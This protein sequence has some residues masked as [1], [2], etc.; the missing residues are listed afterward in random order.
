MKKTH[1]FALLLALCLVLTACGE[2]PAVDTPPAGDTQ[3]TQNTQGDTQSSQN[4]QDKGGDSGSVTSDSSMF[5]D[6]DLR[7]TYDDGKAAVITLSGTSASCPSN[8]VS[9]SGGAVTIL[10]EGTYILT[11]TLTD[12][13]IVVNAPKDAKTQLVLRD[14]SVHSDSSAALYVKAADK[15]VVTLEGENTLSCG[16]SFA[17]VDENNIDGA[18]YAKADITF[19]GSGSLTVTS[20]AG[21]GIV[22]KDDV[23]FA[24][25]SYDITCASHGVDA[26][27][28]VRIT[29]SHL[30]VASGKDAIHAENADDASLGFV[31]IEKGTFLLQAEGDG[32]SAG[33]TLD[34]LGGSFDILC[35]GGSE[36]GSKQSSDNWG[37]FGGGMMPGGMMPGGMMPG[38]M[39]GTRPGGMGSSQQTSTQGESTSMKGFKSTGDLSVSGG[40]FAVDSAD[41]AF[42]S[43]ANLTVSGGNFT[44][45]TG[46]D[47]FHADENL[48]IADGTISISE[49]YEGLEG[50]DILISGGKIDLVSADDGINAAGGTDQSGGG[51]RDQF[52]G[53]GGGFG[54]G[55]GNGSITISGGEIYMQA[56]GDGI[57]ANGTLTISGG[58]TVV[59][60]P[61]QG[62]TAVLDYD[63]T[64]IITGGTFIGTGSTMMAQTFSEGSTQGVFAVTCGTQ[65]AGSRILLT[66]A[67][68][69]TVVDHTPDLSFGLVVLSTPD[70]VSGQDYTITI[71]E[72][73]GTFAAS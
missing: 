12:G 62:D 3:S 43:N 49:S 20:P 39:G 55:S 41:D 9:V 35:G 18:V 70:M 40:I 72:A 60:G 64:A 38:G 56:S 5:T 23:V 14:V 4:T 51:G 32:I 54:M 66:D 24:G 7:S 58:Y 36:N 29:G 52:G 61:T 8:A 16:E 19:N 31:F 37:G 42:H 27:D 13:Q 11:G 71:G 15:V 21:H 53:M 34:I 26:N 46:D 44:I 10:D 30:T 1:L 63:K 69:N 25:G 50:L 47:G 67:A 17:A 33:G 65:A 68:G 22:G 57:D 45:A 73:S 28:S 59:C 48:T 2:T 6:R